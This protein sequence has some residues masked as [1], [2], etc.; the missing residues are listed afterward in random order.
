[1][2]TPTLRVE[3]CYIFQGG[4]RRISAWGFSQP[5]GGRIKTLHTARVHGPSTRLVNTGVISARA[6][7][8]QAVFIS[9]TV[10]EGIY[11]AP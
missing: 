3:V 2:Q 7:T 9:G 10:G 8:A 5:Q 6:I 4:S 11:P 1:M